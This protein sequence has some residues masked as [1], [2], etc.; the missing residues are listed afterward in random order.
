[1]TDPV[2]KVKE[3]RAQE[4]AEARSEATQRLIQVCRTNVES[5]RTLAGRGAALDPAGM[6]H[7][8]MELLLELLFGAFDPDDLDT[9]SDGRLSYELAWAERLR[10]ILS[11][12]LIETT[13]QGFAVPKSG[14][15]VPPTK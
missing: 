7:E 1:M 10:K 13:S 9:V 15:I 11:Q 5:V 3:R 4:A 6:T 8:R 14:L 12:A 2:T